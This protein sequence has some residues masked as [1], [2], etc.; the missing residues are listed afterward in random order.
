MSKLYALK[1]GESKKYEPTEIASAVDGFGLSAD[2]KKLLIS[3]TNK[4]L[5]IADANGQKVDMDKSKLELNNW[6]FVVNPPED[7]KE[8]YADAWRMMRDFFYDRDLHKVDWA[9][10]KKRYEPLLD[11][12]T[13]R[14]ELD[15]LIS[16][17]VG[18][19]SALHTFV[20]GG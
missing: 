6:N 12:I 10:V 19:L 2:K 5:A 3:F 20:V 14:D 18:E 4:T 13:D 16:Q 11:R 7:W 1:I 17:M 15:D 8:M 9:E